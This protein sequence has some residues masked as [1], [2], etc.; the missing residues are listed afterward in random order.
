MRENRLELR[1]Q[2]LPRFAA[3]AHTTSACRNPGNYGLFF[4]DPL[5]CLPWTAGRE[6]DLGGE[7]AVLT[8]VDEE[9]RLVGF[10][11]RLE[12]RSLAAAPIDA[13]G[14]H[15]LKINPRWVSGV[16]GLDP[17]WRSGAIVLPA[18]TAGS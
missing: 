11:D 2:N 4:C 3:D 10:G 17:E 13:A 14:P 8:G 12:D 16:L 7:P 9:P 15:P 1:R 5:A 6:A 18:A